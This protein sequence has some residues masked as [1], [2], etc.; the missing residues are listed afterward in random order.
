MDLVALVQALK[1][2]AAAE[3]RRITTACAAAPSVATYVRVVVG[4][5][6]AFLGLVEA[7]IALGLVLDT[8]LLGPRLL[9][10]TLLYLLESDAAQFEAVVGKYTRNQSKRLGTVQVKRQSIQHHVAKVLAL[11]AT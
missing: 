6:L 11:V 2:A 10:E 5:V 9:L 1:A 3:T 7:R 4:I 8:Q